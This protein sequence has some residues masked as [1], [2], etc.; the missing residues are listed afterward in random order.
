MSNKLNIVF[1]GTPD[2]ALPALNILAQKHNVICVY[3]QNP[4]PQG[5]GYEF[6]PSPIVARATE[7]GIEVRTPASLK[8]T[9]EQVLFASL[10]ADVAVVAAYGLILPEAILSAFPMGCI[11]IHGSILP[12][13]RGAAPIQRAIM[14]GDEVTGI[15]IMQ[16]AAGMDT[17]DMLLKKTTV[18]GNKTADELFAEL[19]V[20]G[21]ELIDEYLANPAKYPPVKQ[22]DSLATL[23]PKIKKEEGLL[24]FTRTAAELGRIVRAIPTYFIYKGERIK[25]L[26]AAVSLDENGTPKTTDIPCG[27][28]VSDSEIA[29]GDGTVLSLL[30]LQRS[31]K[32]PLPVGEFLKGF[33]FDKEVTLCDIS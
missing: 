8:L 7:L 13:W 27:R 2:F 29:C 14:A 9:E 33:R 3:S 11:N 4:K 12:R 32:K 17:G 22:D 24:D 16:M 15:T 23:A 30:R 28:F 21:A 31:G 19:S 6:I 10:N 25:V 26:A 1:M 18:T 5:R 20:M